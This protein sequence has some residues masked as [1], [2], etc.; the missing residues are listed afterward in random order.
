M[1]KFLFICSTFIL[2][3][4]IAFS[5]VRSLKNNKVNVRLGPSK[6]YPI[7]FVY[8]KKYLPVVIIDEHY[9]WRKVR[10]YD[11]DTGWVH[12]SQLSKTKTTVTTKNNQVVYSSPSIYSKPKVKLEIYQVLTIKQCNQTWCEIKNAKTNGWVQKEYLWAIN[13]HKINIK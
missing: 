9:N 1:G 7:K 12:I 11:N 10:D 13:Q 5:E 8:E 3:S 4:S 6:N 2:V